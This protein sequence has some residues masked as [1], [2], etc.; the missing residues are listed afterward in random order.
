M[1]TIQRQSY[2]YCGNKSNKLLG[3]YW[4]RNYST[5]NPSSL[6]TP[7]PI[8]TISNLQDKDNVLSKRELLL[9][10]GGIYS[11]INKTYGKQ[12]IGSAKDLYIRLNEHLSK[13]KSNSAL[14][15]AILKHGLDNFNFCI[16][17]VF[18]S[19]LRENKATSFK[20][21]TD[22][23]TMYIKNFEFS[24]LYHFMKNATSLEGYKHTDEAKEKM[25]KRFE[26]KINHPF[27]GKH[28]N[29]K[30]KSLISKPGELNPMFGKTHSE[31]TRD[32]IRSK[33]KKYTN[34]VGLYDLDNKL[35][36]RFDYASD[37]AKHLNVSKVT[38]SKYINGGLVYKDK[39]YLKVNSNT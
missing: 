22:L 7:T 31:K 32:L 8:L 38:V 15:A 4:R 30:S 25:V 39:Y 27:W 16:Y 9:N 21:L 6:D 33:K 11:F 36:K 5:S 24:N 13:R 3:I 1:T 18:S 28:H 2:I 14:Q 34:G 10:K 12:Y 37:L 35:I 19:A 26:D 23:E 17:E 29:E 20:L